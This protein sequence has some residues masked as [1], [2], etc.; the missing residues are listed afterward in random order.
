MAGIS[1]TESSLLA[2]SNGPE[3][4]TIL[5]KPDDAIALMVLGHGSATPIHRPLMAQ[6]AEALAN[7]QIATFRYNYP[8]SESMTTCSPD[9]VDPLDVLLAT[10]SS[11]KDAA[12]T[13]PLDLPLFLGGRSMSS[14]VMSLAMARDAW[15]SVRGVVL[16]VFP[17]KWDLL[18]ENTV[19]HLSQVPVPML[20]VQGGRDEEFTD[21]REFQPV[22]EG[23]GNRATLHVVADADHSYDLPGGSGRTKMDVLY[24]VASVTAA[25]IRR[26]LKVTKGQ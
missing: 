25:W 2:T 15:P 9:M 5:V 8:Y 14:Q 3:V 11:A 4:T 10:T 18:L 23:L 7:Q 21:L 17:M 24:E 19:C 13:L 12:E 20:F 6:M 26:Q 1:V 16:Y 22:L